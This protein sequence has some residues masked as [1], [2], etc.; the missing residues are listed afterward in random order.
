MLEKVKSELESLEK[1]LKRTQ[2]NRNEWFNKYLNNRKNNMLKRVFQ[3]CNRDIM[4]LQDKIEEKKY[5]IL[6][7]GRKLKS[8]IIVSKDLSQAG[9]KKSEYHAS[10]MVRG[11]GT[12]SGEFIVKNEATKIRIDWIGKDLNYQKFLNYITEKYGKD[13][14]KIEV[15]KYVYINK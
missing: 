12:Y 15:N 10:G 1:E 11:Y 3:K 2:E 5:Q 6:I 9:F 14:I 13:D 8:A 7:G 4:K